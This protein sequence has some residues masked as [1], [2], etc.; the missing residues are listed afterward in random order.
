[1]AVC[2]MCGGN[3]YILTHVLVKV[4]SKPGEKPQPKYVLKKV[5]CPRC[6]GSG[7]ERED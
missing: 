5:K 7:R 6:G 4:A 2:G 3:R 1:M